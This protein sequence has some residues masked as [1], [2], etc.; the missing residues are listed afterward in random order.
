MQQNMWSDN[1]TAVL[2]KYVVD[3]MA[4]TKQRGNQ[5]IMCET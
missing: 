4:E 1:A 5:E 3:H 2:D